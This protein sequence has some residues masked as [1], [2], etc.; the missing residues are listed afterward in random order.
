MYLNKH[1]PKLKDQTSAGQQALFDRGTSIGELARQLFPGGVDAS[2]ENY[3]EFQQSVA[4]TQRLIHDGESVIYEAAF[5]HEGVLAAIDILV[6]TNG[7]WRAYEVKSS[8][9]IK[10]TFVLDA[11]L[12]YQVITG[13]GL[14]LADLSIIYINNQYVR[15]GELEIKKLFATESILE[16]ILEQQPFVISQIARLKDVLQLKEVPTVDIGEHCSIPYGCDFMGHC[17]QHIPQ[18]SVFD[19]AN[20]REK[21]KFELYRKGVI[22]FEDITPDVELNNH[23]RLQVD[24]HLN[25]REHIDAVGIREFL[26]TLSYPM[27]YLDFETFN[28]A[29]PLY[30]RS[31]PYQQIP[32]QYSIHY[33]KER[34]GD[35]RHTEFLAQGTGDP[36]RAFIENL[37]SKTRLPGT[38]LTYNQGFEKGILKGLA[39]AFPE[40]AEALEDRVM[41][42]KDI[43]H[44]FQQRLY[45]TPAMQGSYSIKEVLPALVP[46]LG[47]DELL[48]DN[49]SDA[50]L[51][52]EQLIYDLT[53]DKEE[54]RKNLLAYCK[55]DTLAMV[56]IL[57]KLE[58]IA[59]GSIEE[60]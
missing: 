60:P 31:W 28:P 35:L 51:Y 7:K 48:I 38:I 12:Q 40:Y 8:T 36:R 41:R 23:Q 45:Y 2:P 9:S 43:M 24:A 47:Y 59:G 49:G 56:R 27:Y 4:Y 33:K 29:V 55:M 5:Q 13:A 42:I 26:S 30:D 10:D 21:R 16:G 25:N 11:A 20:L 46:A 18:P 53:A 6:K 52:F 14:A 15:M 19:L 37:L 1:Q 17:W 50:S 3:Y 39:T 58:G 22:R 57:E 34:H 44:P 54:I 32:F